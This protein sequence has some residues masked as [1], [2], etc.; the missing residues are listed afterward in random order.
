MQGKGGRTARKTYLEKIMWIPTTVE[1]LY[2]VYVLKNII[3]YLYELTH[4][5]ETMLSTRECVQSDKK[6]STKT[7]LPLL[8]Q[9]LTEVL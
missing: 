8:E 4:N 3:K 5:G 7:V 2:N 9:L 1:D 6:P